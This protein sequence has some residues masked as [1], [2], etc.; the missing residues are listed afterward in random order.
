V[1]ALHPGGV[2]GL[3]Q[4]PDKPVHPGGGAALTGRIEVDVAGDLAGAQVGGDDELP[5][6]VGD[7]NPVVGVRAPRTG[8]IVVM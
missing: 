1:E 5:D 8:A 4:L 2:G 3:L 7:A 6:R